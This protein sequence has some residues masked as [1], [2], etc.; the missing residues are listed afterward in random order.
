[1]KEK[2]DNYFD[3]YC[4]ILTTDGYKKIHE[5]VNDQYVYLID[6][7]NNT[8]K[9][10]IWFCGYNQVV[11]LGFRYSTERIICSS[12]AKF[13]LTD[14]TIC[15]A[16]NTLSKKLKTFS[17]AETEVLSINRIGKRIS[18]AFGHIESEPFLGIISNL[19]VKC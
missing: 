13:K 7:D 19:I 5:L 11:E 1:M 16:E 17:N 6:E 8:I 9:S 2:T 10:E 14:D 3:G 4:N 15:E 18:F 12:K